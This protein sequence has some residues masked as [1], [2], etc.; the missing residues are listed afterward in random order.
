MPLTPLSWVARTGPRPPEGSGLALTSALRRRL[1]PQGQPWCVRF[2]LAPRAARS[3]CRRRGTWRTRRYGRS[4]C[5]RAVP[6]PTHATTRCLRAP[7]EAPRAGEQRATTPHPEGRST[8]TD[9][10]P[11]DDCYPRIKERYPTPRSSPGRGRGADG[12]KPAC[13]LCRKPPLPQRAHCARATVESDPDADAG[14]GHGGEPPRPACPPTTALP[15][16]WSDSDAF[17][18]R[19]ALLLAERAAG[20]DPRDACWQR[21]A[22]SRSAPGAAQVDQPQPADPRGAWQ[23]PD[24][25][26]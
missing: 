15:R 16:L 6:H 8:A 7:I 3:A 25:F 10:A 4:T 23:A 13:A 18:H 14:P 1:P 11:R 21:F 5:Y 17:C 24:D 22:V 20:C 9:A 19:G 26:C 2:R 12:P